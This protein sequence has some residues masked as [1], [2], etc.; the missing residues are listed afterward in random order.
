VTA[1][2]IRLLRPRAYLIGNVPGL[3]DSTQW[4]VVQSVIGGLGRLGYCV[5]DYIQLDAA[6]YGVPQHRVRPF[7]FGHRGGPCIS[8]P[9]PTHSAPT[10]GQMAMVGCELAPWVTCRQA[11]GHLSAEEMGRPIRLRLRG[12]GGHPPSRLDEPAKVVL[13]GVPRLDKGGAV[14]NLNTRHPPGDPDAPSHTIGAKQ[15]CQSG[16]VMR[17]PQGMR[18]GH[19][20]KPAATVTTQI[21][22]VGAGA[23]HVVE[24]PEREPDPNRPPADGDRPHRTVTTGGRGHQAILAWPW[25]RPAT[26]V[27]CEQR[28]PEPGHH[29]GSNLSQ[30]NAV[31]L[32]ERAAAILQGFPEDWH[33][34]GATKAARWSQIGQ[35]MPPPLAEAVA[36]SVLHQIE[37]TREEEAA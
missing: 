3:D 20:D 13:A 30:P 1:E 16:H 6:D 27:S 19:A 24:W 22:R 31:V 37:A 14:L 25:D 2:L 9:A 4:H 12:D 11:L 35:A 29:G 36:R 17:V 21:D 33:F 10:G 7:W 8:W 15:R 34:A 32:S 28:I 18:V 23:G 26:G 5:A